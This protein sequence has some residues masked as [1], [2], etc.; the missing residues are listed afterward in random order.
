MKKIFLVSLMIFSTSSAFA[1]TLPLSSDALT[2]LTM[3]GHVPA[4]YQ[5][6][7]TYG[8]RVTEVNTIEGYNKKYEIVVKHC[9]W[10]M[11]SSGPDYVCVGG[12]KM[13]VSLV[14][15]SVVA[16]EPVLLN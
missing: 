2:V 9:K 6:L 3:L 10:E 16:S 14:G 12:A 11:Q 4:Q 15:A 8:N 1:E 7:M 13:E 5:K